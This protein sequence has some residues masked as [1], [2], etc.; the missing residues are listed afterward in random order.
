MESLIEQDYSD[1][2]QAY[3]IECHLEIELHQSAN[4]A[5]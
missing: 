1:S 4:N 3:N 2:L 5:Q